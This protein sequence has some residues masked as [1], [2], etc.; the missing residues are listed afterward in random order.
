MW[1][2]ANQTP[3]PADRTWVRDVRGQ[4]LWIVAIKATYRIGEQGALSL[5]EEQLPP[6]HTS[7]HHSAADSSSI[8]FSADLTPP[9][10]GTDILVNAL[11]HVPGGRPGSEVHVTLRA[12]GFTKTIVVYG[13]RKFVGSSRFMTSKPAPFMT[14]PIRYELAYGGRDSRG[15]DPRRQ[16]F[17]ARNPIGRGVSSSSLRGQ[18]A[19]R[20][21]YPGANASKAGPAGFGALASHWSPRREL[22]GTY[23]EHWARTKRPLLADDYDPRCQLSSPAD[24]RPTRGRLHG[25]ERIELLNMTPSGWLAIE[26]PTLVF[27]LKTYFG[28]R[29]VEHP[30]VL[31]TAHVDAENMRLLLVWQSSLEVPPSAV[32]ALDFT[33]IALEHG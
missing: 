7:T 24:Q 3:F 31:S 11:A 6:L 16:L 30:A 25:G 33:Q 2:V 8:E 21:E 15:S 29:S 4:H 10:P 19:H 26:V 13:E 17:D 14:C 12:A 32:D 20:I 9:K 27:S 22:A 5:A 28:R 23:D 1:H 18:P